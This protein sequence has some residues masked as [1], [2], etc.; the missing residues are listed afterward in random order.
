M[1]E[2][3]RLYC[4][5]YGG[6]GASMYRAWGRSLPDWV[7]VV[8]VHFPGREHRIRETPHSH[9][10]PLVDEVVAGFAQAGPFAFFGHSMGTLAAFEVARALRRRGG[11]EPGLLIVSGL[12]AP[13]VPRDRP[14][15]TDLPQEEFLEQLRLHFD[16][17]DD[18]LSDP[19]L[20]EMV[21]PVLRADLAVVENHTYTPEPP[22]DFPIV[23]FGGETD[24]EARPDHIAAWK[25]QSVRPVP[26]TLFPGGHFYVNAHRERLLAAVRTALAETFG[27]R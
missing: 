26:V 4:F 7:E 14:R 13:Q 17:T 23:A 11:P 19:L 6:A 8:P 9:I 21:L 22:F 15:I 2:K 25:D 16:V 27:G 3:V 24:P 20:L 10:A 1:S 12:G 18:L 5:P